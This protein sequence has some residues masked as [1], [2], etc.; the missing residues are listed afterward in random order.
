MQGIKTERQTSKASKKFKLSDIYFAGCAFNYRTKN[1]SWE[2]KKKQKRMCVFHMK[3]VR[4]C[5]FKYTIDVR[6]ICSGKCTIYIEYG[7][8]GMV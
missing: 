6:V 3:C 8:I 2:W 7:N 4:F 5:I 1:D